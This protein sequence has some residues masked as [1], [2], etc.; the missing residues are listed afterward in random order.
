MVTFRLLISILLLASLCAALPP[1][2]RTGWTIQW[3][4]CASHV[5]QPLKNTSLP[6]TLPSTLHCGRLN[7]PMDY[8]QPMSENNTITL[9]FSMYRPQN[10]QGL[11]NFNPGGPG[12]EAASYGWRF[13]LNLTDA[14]WF[15][16]LEAF[17]IL[18][19]DV[20]GTYSSNPLNCSLGN[21]T[22]SSSLPAS[23]SEFKAL[24]TAVGMYAQSCIDLST[25]NGIVSHVGTSETV[26][27]WES[28]RQALGYEKLHHYGIS[29]GTFGGATYANK[30]P[31]NVGRF[32]LDAVFAPGLRNLEMIQNQFRAINRLLIRADVYCL[33]DSTCPFHS[34]G[35][36]SVVQ[37]FKTVLDRASSNRSPNPTADDVRNMVAM[38]YL[39]GDPDFPELNQA[40]YQAVK[41][42]WTAFNY[43][44]L[45][46]IYTS[47]IMS[48]APIYC[49]DYH[50]D[51]NT[52][53]G[54]NKIRQASVMDDPARVEYIFYLALHSVCSGWPYSAASNPPLYV[55][56][57]MTLVTSDFDY[58]TPTES[59]TSE[60]KQAPNSVLVVRHGDD[61]GT[62][63][64]PGP[65]R[66]AFIDFLVTGELPR[67]VNQT[68]A[69]IYEPRSKR[70][71]VP[72]PYAVPGE[73]GLTKLQLP[74]KRSLTL[75][76]PYLIP[77]VTFF[78][79]LGYLD[80]DHTLI[81]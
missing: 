2:K 25:P 64:V 38:D 43:T 10:S 58:N 18:A 57:P 60:W 51:D 61:H 44:A 67:A 32:A 55:D 26:Q 76:L 68:F 3:I 45:A 16:G 23:E 20:R 65:A 42:N 37:A 53:N 40:L 17:D 39:V 69:T 48:I 75:L 54:F 28:L 66:S 30:Y 62:Y 21:W 8:L 52:L 72:D 35:K 63:N 81:G 4:D 70:D 71:P 13:A 36:G 79:S 22:L 78:H 80:I 34:Q 29:Y 6:A 15:A 77:F 12:Q 49:L 27:D 33:N 59:A 74:P 47:A 11:I 73:R 1:L 5:P 56:I 9:G 7:V 46:S 41:G 14:S 31:E 50:N 24:Q 19:M